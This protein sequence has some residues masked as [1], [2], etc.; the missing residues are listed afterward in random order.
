[1]AVVV[2]FH[3]VFVMLMTVIMRFAAML[4]GMGML[5]DMV[6]PMVVGVRVR[7]HHAVMPMFVI[8]RVSMFVRMDVLMFV[9]VLHVFTPAAVKILTIAGP[10]EY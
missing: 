8:M 1:M 2:G 9:F 3:A 6:V 4:V 7:M 5:V 10:D